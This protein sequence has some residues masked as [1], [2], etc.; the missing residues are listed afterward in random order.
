MVL[1]WQASYG[2]P[3]AVSFQISTFDE[4][5]QRSAGP[6]LDFII[7]MGLDGGSVGKVISYQASI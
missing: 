6:C 1:V 4:D 7:Y 3:W 2:F 5:G